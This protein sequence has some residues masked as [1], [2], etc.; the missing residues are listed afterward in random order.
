MDTGERISMILE[1][2]KGFTGLQA[3]KQGELLK[4]IESLL[5][6]SPAI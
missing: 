5:C 6:E 4:F 3:D 1:I 2:I